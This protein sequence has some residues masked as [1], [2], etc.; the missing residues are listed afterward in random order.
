L[1][2]MWPYQTFHRFIKTHQPY[3]PIL[4]SRP[5]RT[6]Y[7]LRDPRDA[8]VSYFHFLRAHQ[9][10][11]YTD[12]FSSFIHHSQFGVK[13][14]IT[15]YQSWQPHIT[16][17]IRYEAL[18]SDTVQ[19]IRDLLAF[20]GID[21]NEELLRMAVANSSVSQLRK[22]QSTVGITGPTRFEKDFQFVRSGAPG[23]WTT[24]FTETDDQFYRDVC[25]QQQFNDYQ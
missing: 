1:R 17:L 15:H 20:S 24:Y 23:D 5:Q 21:I 4:F 8:M 11:R 10:R 18:K 3:R 12:D 9:Q 25:K 6:V 14:Y 7:I 13:A 16:Y 22:A 19:Q 2:K